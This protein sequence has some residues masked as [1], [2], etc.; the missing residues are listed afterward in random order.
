LNVRVPEARLSVHD[1]LPYFSGASAVAAIA[2]QSL[3]PGKSRNVT[4]IGWP[5]A[6]VS[7]SVWIVPANALCGEAPAP[8]NMK[9]PGHAPYEIDAIPLRSLA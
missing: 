2:S 8:A 5:S 6:Y 7:R 3:V 4:V 9:L 1:Q